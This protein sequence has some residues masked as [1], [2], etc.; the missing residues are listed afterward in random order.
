MV[1]DVNLTRG[2]QRKRK[3]TGDGKSSSMPLRE[4]E[5]KHH[6]SETTEVLS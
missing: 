6:K 2:M 1:N 4:E 3:G 5:Q